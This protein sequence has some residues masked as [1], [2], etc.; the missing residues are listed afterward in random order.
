MPVRGIGRIV[1]KKGSNFSNPLPSTDA[2][3]SPGNTLM[4]VPMY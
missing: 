3:S 1:Y 2:D 4:Y